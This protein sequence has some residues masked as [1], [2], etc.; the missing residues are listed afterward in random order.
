MSNDINMVVEPRMVK[1]WEQFIRDTVPYSIALDGYVSGPYRTPGE[2]IAT[3]H[4]EQIDNLTDAFASAARRFVDRGEPV[5]YWV[6]C[7]LAV[8]K[9]NPD[10]QGVAKSVKKY[11]PWRN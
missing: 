5:P 2:Y 10:D 8:L 1:T 3:M 6:E 11:S 9:Q 4:R 7:S